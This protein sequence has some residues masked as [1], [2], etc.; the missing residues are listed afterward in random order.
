M[1]YCFIVALV[2]VLVP[3]EQAVNELKFDEVIVVRS[4]DK[5]PDLLYLVL[6]APDADLD[7]QCELVVQYAKAALSEAQAHKFKGA[8]KDAEKPAYDGGIVFVIRK[9]RE[10]KMAAYTGFSIEQIREILG[11]PPDRGRH[12]VKLHAWSVSKI[13]EKR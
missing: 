4:K 3:H 8:I 10:D 12:L 7:K 13:P 9:T 1:T 11:A 2:A 5:G 6:T